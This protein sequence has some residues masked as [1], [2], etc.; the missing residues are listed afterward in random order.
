MQQSE[1]IESILETYH[2][3]SSLIDS[4]GTLT[5]TTLIAEVIAPIF[6]FMSL[7]YMF[8]TTWIKQGH[9]GKF[10]DSG[11]LKRLIAVMILIPAVPLLFTFI[12]QIGFV[13]AKAMEMDAGDKFSAINQLWDTMNAAPEEEISLWSL[14]MGIIYKLVA[15]VFVILSILLMYI[16]KFVIILFSGVFIQFCI[17]VS[18]LA[19]AFSILPIF[20]D[21]VEKLLQVF[22]NACFVGLTMNILDDMFFKSLFQ[23][24]VLS[25][26][27]PSADIFNYIMISSTCFTIVIFY[28]LSFWLTAKYVGSPGAAAIMSTAVTAT[29]MAVMAGAKM[30]GGSKGMVPGASGGSSPEAN[31]IKSA[32]QA[33]KKE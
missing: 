26:N 29:T 21:Q 24:V 2:N 13:T 11:E 12:Q 8:V 30:M 28:L 31:I 17:I 10:M 4:L 7:A 5:N 14:T 20:K 33:I 22:F 19:M 9:R 16:V 18:P 6:F 15:I 23:K 3:P 25:L 1:G 27:E 32:A